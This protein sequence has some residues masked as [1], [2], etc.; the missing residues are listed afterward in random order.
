MN[1]CPEKRWR[2]NF[3]KDVCLCALFGMDSWKRGP[4][5]NFTLRVLGENGKSG[6]A[7]NN[8]KE[9][10]PSN[11]RYKHSLLIMC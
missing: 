8:H 3:H 10:T 11:P 5:L 9:Y 2:L 1:K 7:S 6:A 4:F